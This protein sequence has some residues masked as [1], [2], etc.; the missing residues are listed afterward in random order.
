[1]AEQP[2]L[3]ARLRSAHLQP[4]LVSPGQS[5]DTPAVGARGTIFVNAAGDVNLVLD[6]AV[7]FDRPAENTVIRLAPAE[8]ASLMASRADTG[9][10][11]IRLDRAVEPPP[12]RNYVVAS[13]RL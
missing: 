9:A 8:V 13:P 3:T 4:V 7:M 12:V 6:Y 5:R 1:M 11:A 10:Y 2:Q